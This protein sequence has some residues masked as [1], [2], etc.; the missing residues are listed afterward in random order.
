MKYLKFTS[1]AY[2]AI[3]LITVYDGITKWNNASGPWLSFGIAAVAV[4]MFFFRTKY[5]KR[6]EDRNK[7][8][9]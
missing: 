5:S 1:Y 9:K 7:T 4:F 6:F 3:A 8:E 2:L